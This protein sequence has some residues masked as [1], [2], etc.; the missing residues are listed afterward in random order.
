MSLYLNISTLPL[1]LFLITNPNKPTTKIFSGNKFKKGK[2][3]IKHREIESK[4][5]KEDLKPRLRA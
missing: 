5:Q 1:L 2:Q 3:Q 4:E